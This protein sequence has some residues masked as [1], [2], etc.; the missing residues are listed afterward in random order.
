VVV[1]ILNKN[2]SC[3]K[4][5]VLSPMESGGKFLVTKFETFFYTVA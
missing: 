2:T 1:V 4:F 5:I 3:R